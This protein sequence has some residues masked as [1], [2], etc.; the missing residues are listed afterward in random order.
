MH[1]TTKLCKFAQLRVPPNLTSPLDV[2]HLEFSLDEP[3]D[4]GD[5]L[6][7]GLLGIVHAGRKAHGDK[8]GRTV[9]SHQVI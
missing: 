6:L 9:D 5:D 2:L 8:A 1:L 3:L 7:G 4:G